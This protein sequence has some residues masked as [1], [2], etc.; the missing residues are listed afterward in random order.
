MTSHSRALVDYCSFTIQA[1]DAWIDEFN[2][3]IRQ[4]QVLAAMSKVLGYDMTKILFPSLPDDLPPRFPYA[5]GLRGGE[6]GARVYFSPRMG[7]ILVDLSGV[8][9][10]NIT[11]HDKWAELL[12]KV[13]KSLTRLDLTADLETDMTP[14][15][16]VAH[17]YSNRFSYRRDESSSDGTSIYIGSGKSDRRAVVYRFNPPHPR[18]RY[19]RVEH[20]FRRES[21]KALGALIVEHGITE[22]LEVAGMVFDWSC[23]LWQPR[24]SEVL[25]YEH[26]LFDVRSSGEVQ[27]V[28]KQVVPALKRYER[29]GKIPDLRAF[30]AEYLHDEE[31]D[32]S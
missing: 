8:P 6:T 28:L 22:A 24:S 29:E 32:P 4:R 25:A 5:F 17:G 9:C 12:A 1:P 15:A 21:A 18:E 31:D 20:R 26:M 23:P 7:H 30:L 14:A 11:A 3:R 27:W 19:L 13:A 16:F 10:N 2:P